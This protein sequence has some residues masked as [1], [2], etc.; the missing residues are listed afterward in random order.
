MD[1]ARKGNRGELELELR[2]PR[3]E[4]GGNSTSIEGVEVVRAPL[5]ID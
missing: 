5:E 3:D 4:V 2:S 1:R